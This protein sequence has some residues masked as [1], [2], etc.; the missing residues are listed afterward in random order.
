VSASVPSRDAES[1][2]ELP[3]FADDDESLNHTQIE[4]DI[5]IEGRPLSEWIVWAEERALAL[6]PFQD[7][8]KGL[9]E[10]IR[11]A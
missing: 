11:S 2:A 7:G 4:G 3:P 10:T 1:A 6:D 9:F 5:A 8:L